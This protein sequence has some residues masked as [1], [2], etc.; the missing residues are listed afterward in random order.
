MSNLDSDITQLIPGELWQE[1]IFKHLD[2]YTIYAIRQINQTMLR[3]V[4]EFD[5]SSLDNVFI[6][7]IK[8]LSAIKKKHPKTR[9]S[10]VATNIYDEDVILLNPG[11]VSNILSSKFYMLELN[12][13]TLTD[14][15]AA[16][17][18]VNY[19]ITILN[20]LYITKFCG[21]NRSCNPTILCLHNCRILSEIGN[22]NN[23]VNLEIS[24]CFSLKKISHMPKLKLLDIDIS[25]RAFTSSIY[26]IS[27]L[28]SLENLS[29]TNVRVD[30]ISN[31]PALLVLNIQNS[32][33]C[34]LISNCPNIET[35]VDTSDVIDYPY[36]TLPNLKKISLIGSKITI[37]NLLKSN[38][39]TTICI[40]GSSGGG[41]VVIPSIYDL[42]NL[43]TLLLRHVSVDTISNLP[44][45]NRLDLNH[46]NVRLI[47][48]IPRLSLITIYGSDIGNIAINNAKDNIIR[49]LTFTH[50][51]I[52]SIYFSKHTTINTMIWKFILD[53]YYDL[54]NIKVLESYI[55]NDFYRCITAGP[56]CV[57]KAS[58]QVY[59]PRVAMISLYWNIVK[60]NIGLWLHLN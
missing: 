44:E 56:E 26:S 24:E 40:D 23:L 43:E 37:D 7:D 52:D 33:S 36:L 18:D 6:L 4:D 2:L 55:A 8:T 51:N 48:D 3:V 46:S 54:S 57:Y 10:V 31:L 45:L 49:L 11:N 12:Y 53:G 13:S 29:L 34:T 60:Y 22:F 30:I 21:Y 28:P 9:L 50:S 59:L 42:P 25:H 38:K 17:I 58:K 5:G 35:L 41:D 27:D 1:Y 16:N 47:I 39:L 15:L 14:E 19:G 20:S 32:T